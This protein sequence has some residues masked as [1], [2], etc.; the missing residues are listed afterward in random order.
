MKI[1]ASLKVKLKITAD[2]LFSIEIFIKYIEFEI[3]FIIENKINWNPPKRG[4][5]FCSKWVFYNHISQNKYFK[6]ILFPNEQDKWYTMNKDIQITNSSKC[7]SN[8][9]LCTCIFLKVGA[10]NWVIGLN[11]HLHDAHID[12]D[13]LKFVLFRIY[14]DVQMCRKQN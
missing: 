2:V 11:T 12:M 4:V 5:N 3:I 14:N 1:I 13:Q 6:E 8:L 10:L 9:S 7:S